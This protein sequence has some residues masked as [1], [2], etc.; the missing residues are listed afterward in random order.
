MLLKTKMFAVFTL[1]TTFAFHNGLAEFRLELGETIS[2]F[3]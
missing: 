3:H 2:A 1:A